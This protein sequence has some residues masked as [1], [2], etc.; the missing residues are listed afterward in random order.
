MTDTVRNIAALKAILVDNTNGEITPQDIRDFLVSCVNVAET[1]LQTMSGPL[2]VTGTLAATTLTG[3]GSGITALSGSNISSGTVADARL[4]SNVALKN[5][6]NNFSVG[7][8]VTGT[9]AAT[10]LTG[11]G[12]GITNLAASHLAGSTGDIPNYLV[13]NHL[14]Y[15]N[16]DNTFSGTQAFSTL[17]G[18]T[19]DM[20]SYK[21]SGAA[22]ATSHLNNDTGFI[23]SSGLAM[24]ATS[25]NY[26][27]LSGLPT[28][29]GYFSNDVGYITGY[30][31]NVS[32]FSNDANYITSSSIPSNVSYF[33][34]DANYITSS[35]IPSNVSTFTNDAGYLTSSSLGGF[36]GS[37]NY[38]Y[39]SIS[40]GIIMSAS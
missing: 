9:L 26:S 23:T 28:N 37:G 13:S 20:S 7:Q 18:L 36:N 17:T 24:V 32:S 33:S 31:S 15:T 34:N 12:S 16:V 14:A 35:S 3:A 1:A 30:P 40:N 22:L 2:T 39:F 11:N 5:T 6:N 4:S 29:V 10:S 38:T 25:N 27:D 19:C 8:T 21:V